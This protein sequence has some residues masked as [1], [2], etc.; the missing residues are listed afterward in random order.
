MFNEPSKVAVRVGAAVRGSTSVLA[1]TILLPV[2]AF[3]QD[4]ATTEAAAAQVSVPQEEPVLEDRRL[5]IVTVTAQKRSERDLDVPI[6]ITAAS[7]DMLEDSGIVGI[8]QIARLVPGVQMARSGAFSQPAI[9]GI[10]TSNAGPGADNNVAVYVDGFY[11]AFQRSLQMDLVN[12]SQIQVLKGP[13][14]TLFGRNATGG[15]ILISTLDP[16]STPSGRV[17]AT[18]GSF[19]DTSL[20]GY[21]SAPISNDLG[22]VVSGYWRESDGFIEDVSG[23]DPAPIEHQAVSAKLVYDPDSPLKVALGFEA[24]ETLDASG[25][26]YHVIDRSLVQAVYDPNAI[27]STEPH[28]SSISRPNRAKNIFRMYSA[29]ME[30]DADWGT[31]N[32][33]TAYQTSK[34]SV[35]FDADGSPFDSN[36]QILHEDDWALTQ[37][38]QFVSPE[39]NDVSFVGGIFYILAESGYPDYSVLLPPPAAPGTYLAL[40]SFQVDTD[41]IAAYGDATWNFADNWYLTGGVRYGTEKRHVI[42]R[43]GTTGQI[44]PGADQSA[45]FENISPRLVI[46]YQL[47]EDSNVYASYTEGYKAGNYNLSAPYGKIDPEVLAAYEVGYKAAFDNLRINASAYYYQYDDLQV[48]SFVSDG[49]GRANSQTTNAATAEVKGGELEVNFSAFENFDVGASVAYIDATYTKFPE[50]STILPNATTGLYGTSCPTGAGGSR[51]CADDLTSQRLIRSPE[52]SANLN[53]SYVILLQNES[54]VTLTANVGYSDSYAP[55][56]PDRPLDPSNVVNGIIQPGGSGFRW[57]QPA[58]TL[59]NLRATWNVNPK[60]SL[61]AFSNNVTDEVYYT[62]FTGNNNGEYVGYAEPRVVGVRA[63][64]RF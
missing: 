9:R 11:R 31:L 64:V 16:T 51:P 40:S 7:S 47:S 60:L 24:R 29:N 4:D 20:T 27:S 10:S 38:L 45:T 46:R 58:F 1:L 42:V 25:L 37:E 53:L 22:L 56:R 48:T 19:N 18:Y 2:M 43:S 30:W 6:A 39:E 41:A 63:D 59:V 36:D 35:R 23:F 33:Y 5:N 21:Y 55:T 61:S 52:W 34:D 12:L 32:S 62:T 54:D 49:F 50:F 13:Q 17:A 14:G 3:A 57:E 28:V 8:E 26:T 44:L 15:A